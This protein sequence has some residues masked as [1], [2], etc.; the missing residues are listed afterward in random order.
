LV[1]LTWRWFLAVFVLGLAGPTPA[2]VAAL[3]PGRSLL[4]MRQDGV[5]IQKYD[6]SCGAAALAT[7]LTYQ[8]G[9]P[10]SERELARALIRREEYLQ[11]PD[12]VQRRQGFSLLDLKRVVQVRGYKG[13]GY[14]RLTL[15]ALL[16]IAPA[17]VPVR[18]AGYDHFVVFR[19]VE[20]GRALLADP[21]WGNR[22]MPVEQFVR[23]WLD[24]PD[25][26]RVAFV[27]QRPDGTAPPDNRLAPLPDNIVTAPGAVLRQILPV[28]ARQALPAG[29]RQVLP[30]TTRQALP[31]VSP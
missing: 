20:D 19:G 26:G 23:T 22:T 13:V 1:S 12:L 21:A 25:F 15:E 31:A 3:E 2:P 17:I 7:L 30:V 5:V 28:T 16:G 10:V 9:D 18:F 24:S 29:L 6:L 8:H 27:V 11:N 4:E 14:G